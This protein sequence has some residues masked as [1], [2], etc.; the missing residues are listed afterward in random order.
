M[1]VPDFGGGSWRTC[2]PLVHARAFAAAAY[3]PSPSPAPPSTAHRHSVAA[4]PHDRHRRPATT[5]SLHSRRH[6]PPPPSHHQP[7]G[8]GAA[9]SLSSLPKP[10]HSL[11]A[12][13]GARHGPARLVL[14]GGVS[15]SQRFLKT[16]EVLDLTGGGLELPPATRAAAEEWRWR[17]TL[18]STG[19]GG[20]HS[21]QWELIGCLRSARSLAQVLVVQG[22]LYVA[23]G[24]SE[25]RNPVH[26]VERLRP[27]YAASWLNSSTLTEDPHRPLSDESVVDIPLAPAILSLPVGAGQRRLRRPAS[28]TGLAAMDSLQQAFVGV[29]RRVRQ[30]CRRRTA[31]G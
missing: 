3:L 26:T 21:G 31:R 27:S 6:A 9:S 10:G 28:S 29:A 2:A 22:V 24:L 4:A 14:V 13:R 12:R 1:F 30:R 8:G 7:T 25:D 23:G 19:G 16:A 5:S 11:A 15:D 20:V 18:G 17:A